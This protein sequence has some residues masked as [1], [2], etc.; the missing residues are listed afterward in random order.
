MKSPARKPKEKLSPQFYGPYKVIQRIGEVT[1][2]LELPEGSKIHPMFHIS[3]LKKAVKPTCSRQP[4]ATT[5]NENW[6]VPV[7]PK[8]V[9]QD[10][11]SEDGR[12]W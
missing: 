7:Q 4:L 9:M 5:L 8:K 10:I 6:E 11:I 12:R 2:K 3:L 1:Y